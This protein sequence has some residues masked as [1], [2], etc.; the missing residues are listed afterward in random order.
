MKL[1]SLTV[2]TLAAITLLG[3]ATPDGNVKVGGTEV[4]MKNAE[5]VGDAAIDAAMQKTTYS[6]AVSS[7]AK[8]CRTSKIDVAAVQKALLADGY[9]KIGKRQRDNIDVFMHPD[10]RPV[11]GTATG[12]GA[13]PMCI[14]LLPLDQAKPILIE[15]ELR[16]KMFAD[17]EIIPFKLPK[18][19]AGWLVDGNRKN[20]LLLIKDRKSSGIAYITG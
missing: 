11:M 16:K 3:C 10:T 19:S 14:A 13:Q 18:L 5:L 7:L 2:G 4:N 12:N 9:L 6:Q 20:M 8:Y 17:L 15:A 1:S